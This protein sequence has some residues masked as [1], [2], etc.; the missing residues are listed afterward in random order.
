MKNL[1]Q[2]L[3]A[4]CLLFTTT[5]FDINTSHTVGV[6]LVEKNFWNKTNFEFHWLSSDNNTNICPVD[7]T[8]KK[9]IQPPLIWYIICLYYLVRTW[10][11]CTFEAVGQKM[12]ETVLSV[13]KGKNYW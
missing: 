7:R 3:L 2:C 13:L 10:G 12:A 11:K 1:R 6:M 8:V 5:K 4:T 9:Y